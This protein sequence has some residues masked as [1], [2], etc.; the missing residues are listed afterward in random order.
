MRIL[1]LVNVTLLVVFVGAVLRNE[2]DVTE[3]SMSRVTNSA[4]GN[5]GVV[6]AR[7]P[8]R[9]DEDDLPCRNY[10]YN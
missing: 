1:A 3:P 4:T 2:A 6:I 9:Y 7:D 5:T 8:Y 10:C